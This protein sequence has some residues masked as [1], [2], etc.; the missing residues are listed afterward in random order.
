MWRLSS[1][2]HFE[3]GE[4][5]V[6]LGLEFQRLPGGDVKVHQEMFVA[7]LLRSYGLDNGSKSI[8]TVAMALPD[9]NDMPPT[10][11]S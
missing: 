1:E 3:D 5:F 10:R 8:A 9:S 6:F 11:L 4:K 2:Q 7:Q